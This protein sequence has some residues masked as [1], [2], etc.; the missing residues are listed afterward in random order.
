MSSPLVV[1][2]IGKG[3][4]LIGEILGEVLRVFLGCEGVG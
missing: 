2:M 1:V 4:A 3:R